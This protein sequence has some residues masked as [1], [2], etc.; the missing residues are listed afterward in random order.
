VDNIAYDDGGGGAPATDSIVD[1]DTVVFWSDNTYE[2]WDGGVIVDATNGA[3]TPL[4]ARQHN[5][6]IA[7]NHYMTCVRGVARYRSISGTWY[8]CLGSLRL[9]ATGAGEI[10]EFT[11][12]RH[13]LT[14]WSKYYAIVNAATAAAVAAASAAAYVPPTARQANF[15]VYAVPG[16]AAR[17]CGMASCEVNT[18]S[19]TDMLIVT[20]TSANSSIADTCGVDAAQQ[21]RYQ[22]SDGTVQISIYVMGYIEEL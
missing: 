9:D 1:G 22:G 15:R 21:I 13:G 3:G 12:A 6:T 5:L 17:A 20:A 2:T 11:P 10:L 18:A 14:L 8:R 7:D 4:V 19:Y 16:G